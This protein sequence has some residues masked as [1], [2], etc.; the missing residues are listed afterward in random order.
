MQFGPFG[1]FGQLFYP[2]S[3]VW[4]STVHSDENPVRDGGKGGE[5]GYLDDQESRITKFVHFP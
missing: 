1:W 3:N 4:A 5:G 2:D